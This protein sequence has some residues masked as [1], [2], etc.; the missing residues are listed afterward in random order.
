[1]AYRQSGILIGATWFTHQGVHSTRKC[2]MVQTI[3]TKV[4][5]ATARLRAQLVAKV[6]LKVALGANV[7]NVGAIPARNRV[8]TIS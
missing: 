8:S 2:T 5:M 4:E 1:M 7:L 6:V 3:S